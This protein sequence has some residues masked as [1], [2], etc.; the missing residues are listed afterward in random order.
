MVQTRR[1]DLPHID[2]ERLAGSADISEEQALA[3][4]KR[5]DLS[6][7]MLEALVANRAAMRHRSV[8]LEAVKHPRAPRHVSLPALRHLYTFELMQVG[9]TAG[10]PV[11][12]KLAA[13]DTLISRLETMSPGERLTLAK[14]SS[15]RLAA[16]LLLDTEE[17]VVAAALENPH[18]TEESVV[19]ALMTAPAGPHATSALATLLLRHPKWSVRTDVEIA[20]LESGRLRTSDAVLLVHSLS[21]KVLRLLLERDRLPAVAKAAVREELRADASRQD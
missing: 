14:R 1:V 17:Q 18:M 2:N 8:L 3:L 4:L 12:V 16:A 11:D 10:V 20:L 5:R 9:L 6:Q 13:E 7:R 19:K 21:T 15:A